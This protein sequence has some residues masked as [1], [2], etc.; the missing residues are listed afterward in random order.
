MRHQIDSIGDPACEG[1]LVATMVLPL[2][3]GCSCGRVCAVGVG[4]CASSAE[5]LQPHPQRGRDAGGRP[6]TASHGAAAC[7]L[8]EA[9]IG[10][11]KVGGSASSWR[12]S[13]LM[14]SSCPGE[15]EAMETSFVPQKATCSEGRRS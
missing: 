13:K 15:P 10:A 7:T 8:S 9:T 3:R 12:S 11:E 14:R 5:A 6:H 4:E 2:P 1:W